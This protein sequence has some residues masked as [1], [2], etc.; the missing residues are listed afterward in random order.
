MPQ[1][2]PDENAKSKDWKTPMNMEGVASSRYPD[3][4]EGSPKGKAA[5]KK[6]A[7]AKTSHQHGRSG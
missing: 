3:R 1:K 7:A 5:V 4:K 2:Q 6:K